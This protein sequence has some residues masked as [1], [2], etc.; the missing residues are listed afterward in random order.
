MA[1]YGW[2]LFETKEYLPSN[3][4]FLDAVSEDSDWKDGYNGLGWTYAKLMVL[5]SSNSPFYNRVGKETAPMESHRCAIGNSGWSDL[6]QSCF[7][8][9]CKSNTIWSSIPRF[10]CEASDS[11]VDVHPWFITQLSGCS[12]YLSRF[13]FCCWKI[14]FYNFTS[15]GNIGF[16]EFQ[17]TADNR[18][19]LSWPKRNG[20]ADHDPPG[21]PPF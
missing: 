18:Y 4:W 10:Y 21:L 2:E 19:D 20:E 17:W 11:R 8:E 3:A 14:W 16:I 12:N 15:Y 7:R 1:E 13:L 6:C 9:G 5:D